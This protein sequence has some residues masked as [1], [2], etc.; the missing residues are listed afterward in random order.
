M[1]LDLVVR[2]QDVVDVL[3]L[4][5]VL[6]RL[7]LWLRGTVAL[8]VLL[9]MV[10]I[11]ATAL[12]A[13]QVG[14]MLTSYLL[15]GLG[16]VAAL[17][18]VVVFQSEI[19]RGLGRVNPVRWWRARRGDATSAQPTFAA[20]VAGAAFA[21]GRRRT[22]ALMVLPG[23]DSLDEH[24]TGGVDIDA[25]PSPELF[26]AVFHT[27]S[28][29]HDGAAV[30]RAGRVRR[31]GCFLPVSARADLP[32][33]LGS[34][35]RAALGLS[36][37]CDAAVVVASEER[38]DVSLVVAGTITRYDSADRLAARIVELR[39]S[40]AAAPVSVRGPAGHHRVR[41]TIALI[42]VAALV[43]GAWWIVV[44]EPGTVVTRTVSVEMRNV[45]DALEANPPRPDRVAVHVRGPRTRLDTLSDSDVQ[46]WIDLGGAH[47]GRGRY[48]LEASAP[49]GIEITEIVPAEVLVR[50]RPS[51]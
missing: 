18:I 14:L 3:V 29:I 47:A 50:L 21:L 19:R 4:T 15:R 51:E 32:D 9:G 5:F 24:L 36:E 27:A 42:I 26:E 8:Q 33:H 11:A 23:A 34:R 45:P 22:G 31:A 44:G 49:A 25:V 16:A 2:W 20:T 48:R 46:A 13:D 17:A 1:N 28:P 10:V 30:M 7:Y 39:G 6:Y 35:H 43:I 37:V 41:D 12:A 38:G 40:P